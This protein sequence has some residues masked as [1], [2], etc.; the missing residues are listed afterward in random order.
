MKNIFKF[1]FAL[2]ITTIFLF[3]CDEEVAFDAITSAPNADATYYVQFLDAA[4]TM[5]TGVTEAG[6]L[7]EAKSTIAI[8]LMVC[9]VKQISRLI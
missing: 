7:V 1:F 3:S 9:Q 2:S 8:S 5:E 6:G 4:K